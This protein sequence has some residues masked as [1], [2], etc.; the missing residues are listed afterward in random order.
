[1]AIID[2]KNDVF[3]NLFKENVERDIGKVVYENIR[4]LMFSYNFNY[5]FIFGKVFDIFDEFYKYVGFVKSVTLPERK[6]E[7]KKVRFLDYTFNKVLGDN[8]DGNFSLKLYLDSK[9]GL[10]DFIY[11]MYYRNNL[12]NVI[13]LQGDAYLYV[14]SVDVGKILM[15]YKFVGVRVVGIPSLSFNSDE[16]GLVECDLNLVCND[17]IKVN[18]LFK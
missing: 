7:V 17:L 13:Y 4:K 15:Q 6:R 18:E 5:I 10:Y 9:G 8:F 14:L 11:N 1:M 3:S 12:N 16:N 2:N